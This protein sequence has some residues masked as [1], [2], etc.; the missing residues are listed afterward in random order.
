MEKKPLVS[1]IIPVYN[2]PIGLLSE[3]LDSILSL[4]LRKHEREIIVIDDGSQS[5]PLSKL[6]NYLDD[7]IFIRQKNGGLGCARNRGIL[8]VTGQY[9]QFIDADDALIANQYEHCLDLIRFSSPDMVMFN[10]SRKEKSQKIYNDQPAISGR[11]LMRHYNIKATACGY[12][13]KSTILGKLRFT[14]DIFHEDEEFTP[15]LILRAETIIQSDAEAY[16][17]RQRK[18]S[19]TTSENPRNIL[20]RLNDF[21]EVILRLNQTA[22]VIHGIDRLALLR[23]VHQLTMDYIYK[24]IVETRNKHYLERQLEDLRKKGLF[25]LPDRNYTTKYR[26]FRRLTNSKVGLT[27]L[28][29]TIPLIKK[30]K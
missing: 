10:F 28:L 3:C 9:I 8:N 4:S 23:R 25:P 24:I 5:S 16:F 30:E 17:Y 12:L 21:K 1:F 29:R 22:D 11:E 2:I 15:L 26:W 14:P 18:E 27:F 7:I 20:K 19:I 6:D 13:F